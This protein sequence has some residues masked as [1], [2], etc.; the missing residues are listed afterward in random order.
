MTASG[1]AGGQPPSSVFPMTTTLE[2]KQRLAHLY[3]TAKKGLVEY[4]HVFLV[5]DL[6]TELD[7]A[8]FHREWSDIILQGHQHFAVEAFRESAKSQYI[9]RTFPLYALTFPDTRWDYIVIIKSNATLARGK[10]KEI[11]RECMTHPVLRGRLV[12]VNEQSAEIFDVVVYDA[13]G[14]KHNVR[15]EAYGKGASI[16]GLSLKDQRPKILI[17]DDPQDEEDSRSMTVLESDWNWCLSD[18]MFVG[19]SSR[20]F[21]IA[22]NLGERCIIE[23]IIANADSN[24]FAWKRIPIADAAG[25][26]TWAAKYTRAF[27]QQERDAY[28]KMGKIDIWLRERMCEAVAEETRLFHREDFRYFGSYT[29]AQALTARHNKFMSIDPSASTKQTADYRAFV[30]NAVGE[31]RNWYIADCSYGLYD[32]NEAIDELFRLVVYWRLRHV[33]IEEGVLKAAWEPLIYAEMKRRQVF[34]DLAP[35]KQSAKKEIRIAALQP[36]FKAHTIYFPDDAPW[37]AEM[38]AE[39]LSFTKEGTKGMHDDVIDALAYQE[40]MARAPMRSTQT[41]EQSRALPRTTLSGVRHI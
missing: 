26:P 13:Q 2:T 14:K 19:Q 15:I 1:D 33:G 34:F 31:D 16:R 11:E 28:R 7:P 4:R 41:P 30:V 36:R 40:Q 6:H 38:E 32:T 35:L 18:V 10:L 21:L 27:I 3:E 23:R 25:N 24:R 5:N 12:K 39:L 9:M 37:L 22:N 17:I 20:I 29:Q 8:P